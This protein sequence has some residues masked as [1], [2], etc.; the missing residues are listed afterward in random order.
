MQCRTLTE[1]IIKIYTKNQSCLHSKKNNNLQLFTS[2]INHCMIK[3]NLDWRKCS[4]IEAVRG[5]MNINWV[6]F[7]Y[8]NTIGVA[9]MAWKSK[10]YIECFSHEIRFV[11]YALGFFSSIEAPPFL[12]NPFF[13]RLLKK[14]SLQHVSGKYLNRFSKYFTWN[15]IVL[16]INYLD[17]ESCVHA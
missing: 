17:K 8:I 2:C 1:S 11:Y 10:Y 9:T 15:R 13:N 7:W 3:M 14:I 6:I 16:G 12:E 4:L 5:L